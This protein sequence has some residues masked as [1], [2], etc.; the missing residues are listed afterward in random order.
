MGNPGHPDQFSCI[1]CWQDIVLSRPPWLKACLEE[2]CKIMMAQIVAHSKC[3]PEP[4]KPMLPEE[5]EEIPTLYAPLYPLLPP[6][7][8]A[9]K[10]VLE[11]AASPESRPSPD[12]L[13]TL[14]VRLSR[15]SSVNPVYSSQ[16]ATKRPG[17][18]GQP[19]STTV[20]GGPTDA[21]EKD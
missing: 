13:M 9:A 21:T 7:L 17:H 5:P 15:A 6:A 14:S 3:Q 16:K 10:A 18:Q 20:P 8:P 12:S 11:A 2:N 19:L 4:K 1:D